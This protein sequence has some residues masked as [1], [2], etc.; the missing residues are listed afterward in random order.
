MN[1]LSTTDPKTLEATAAAVTARGVR[2]EIVDTR[3][4]AL[5]LVKSLIPAGMSVMTG[6][7]VT[8]KEIGLEDYLISNAHP[9]KNL[10]ADIVAEK[11]PVKQRA[12]RRTAIL[13]DYFL[14]SVHAVVETGE[15]VI[16]SASGSQLGP[17]AFSASN[18]IWIAGAQKIVKT[19]E[20]GI[21]RI[22]EYIM[23][24]EE[25]RMRTLTGGKMGTMLGKLLIFEREP[26]FLERHI[27]LILVKEA[28]GD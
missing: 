26:P 28:T 24:H 8:L 2:T 10:K 18:V 7:S 12:L 4:E 6:A 14:G 21:S 5:A 22:K 15:L 17:Y 27:T 3:A 1:G 9:W 20:E 13:S 16:A 23:P 11:D 19:L 25:E